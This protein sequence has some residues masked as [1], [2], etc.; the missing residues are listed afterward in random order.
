MTNVVASSPVYATGAA[1]VKVAVDA[2][3]LSVSTD[4]VHVVTVQGR[5][6]TYLIFTSEQT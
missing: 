4:Q 3:T 5:Q 2:L 6:D 1:A